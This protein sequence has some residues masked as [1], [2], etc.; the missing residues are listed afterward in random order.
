MVDTAALVTLLAPYLPSLIKGSEKVSEG[1][2]QEAGKDT[3]QIAKAIWEK[4]WP[5][6]ESKEAAKEAVEDF[7]KEVNDKDTEAA[8]RRQLKKILDADET[9]EKQV[10]KLMEENNPTSK[11]VNVEQTGNF[12]QT[13]GDSAK[14]IGQIGSARDITM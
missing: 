3:W 13:A 8:F 7:A 2:L 4:L 11:S 1:L 10:K 5:K 9:L 12:N 6:I 14:Q